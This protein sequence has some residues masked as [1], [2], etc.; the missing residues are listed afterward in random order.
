ME[1]LRVPQEAWDRFFNGV[2]ELMQQ[3]LV[4]VEVIGL[5]VGDQVEAEWVPLL[6]VTYDPKSDSLFVQTST[7]AGM[8]DHSID[9]PREVAEG[10]K[11]SSAPCRPSSRG[12]S[13]KWRS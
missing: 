5:D 12:P 6:G 9:S 2:S 1:F 7:G 8:L 10:M 4:E 3:R 13:G 11:I